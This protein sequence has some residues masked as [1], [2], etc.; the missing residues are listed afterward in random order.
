MDSAVTMGVTAGLL[1][2]QES[3]VS[4]VLLQGLD[5]EAVTVL[6]VERGAGGGVAPDG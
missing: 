5:T 3:Q 4:H 2:L 6:D 1:A